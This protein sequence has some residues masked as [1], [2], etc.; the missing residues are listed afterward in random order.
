MKRLKTG[1]TRTN[2]SKFLNVELF[3]RR[4]KK[5]IKSGNLKTRTTF[6]TTQYTKNLSELPNVTLENST[7]STIRPYTSKTKKRNITNLINSRNLHLDSF[8]YTTYLTATPYWNSQT[9]RN[10]SKYNYTDYITEDEKK[11]DI[12]LK[13]LK[14][15]E[16]SIKNNYKSEK[17]ELIG[18]KTKQLNYD[19]D[20]LF[21]YINKTR[22]L[23]LMKYTVDIKKERNIRL[24]E[25]Y[26]NEQEKI[27]DIMN[28]IEKTNKLFN[29]AFNV[30]FND[31]VKELE[32]N[33]EIAKTENTNLFSQIIKQ[34]NEIAQIESKIKKVE[35]EKNN[36][37][38][39]I[40]FQ[41]LIKEKKLQLPNHYKTLIEETDE[42]IRKI[43]DNPS[44][45]AEDDNM[46]SIERSKK[47]KDTKRN[48][49]FRKTSRK[50]TNLDKPV[51]S[52]KLSTPPGLYKNITL[53]E[54]KRIRYYK[55]NLC[56]P[57][58]EDFFYAMKKF[59]KDTIIFIDSYN[60]LRDEIKELKKEKE[61]V[62]KEKEK[63]ILSGIGLIKEKEF[64]LKIQKNKFNLLN[65]EIYT[66]KGILSNPFN[67]KEKI[68]R[69]DTRKSLIEKSTIIVK[70]K[71]YAH[72]L[73]VYNTCSKIPLN[74]AIN[75]D[76][77]SMKKINTKEEE[78]M[79]MLSKIEIILDYLI[80]I[81]KNYSREK[82]IYYD[83]YKRIYNTIERN[84][85]LE[86]TRKQ[87]EEA[88][89]KLVKLRERVEERNNKI[90]FLPKKKVDNYSSFMVKKEK[91]IQRKESY[92]K[93]LGIDDFMYDNEDNNKKN[94]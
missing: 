36:I 51:L 28:S 19:K 30:K 20:S 38:R 82:D 80:G 13:D 4:E 5:R 67:Q 57:T 37:V 88:N 25:E 86:K 17:N 61:I 6:N 8:T 23:K 11:K 53:N 12:G 69:K 77:L 47:Y 3:E 1:K 74:E 70:K 68:K 84:R 85:K 16:L 33:R 72:I 27:D 32:I 22:D 52:Y 2:K 43:F 87:R 93:E 44:N 45:F 49:V 76:V 65:R 34:K 54:A 71:L 48:I 83:L 66:L 14:K 62:E 29:E 78:M 94:D 10:N 35:Y 90:Y 81:M 42:N 24:K 79:D 56:F 18:L 7:F 64:E 91:K 39:W 26:L 89:E 58:P 59:E 63:E 15:F 46:K 92:E 9:S 31:Y 55:Y 50:S 60:D 21:D 75:P 41:I 73:K 40:F